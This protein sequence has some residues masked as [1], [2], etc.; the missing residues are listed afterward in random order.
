MKQI[1]HPNAGISDYNS[2]KRQYFS[3]S[4]RKV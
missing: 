2:T 3:Y 1:N 4:V